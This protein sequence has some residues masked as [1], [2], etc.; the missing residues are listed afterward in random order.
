MYTAVLN[1]EIAPNWTKLV[2]VWWTRL[3]LVGQVGS[4]NI[5]R[6]QLWQINQTKNKVNKG[7][8]T[9]KRYR[10]YRESYGKVGRS[11][12]GVWIQVE[13]NTTNLIRICFILMEFEISYLDQRLINL[14][15]SLIDRTENVPD[16]INMGRLYEG[17]CLLG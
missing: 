10:F 12:F 14:A 17:Q 15:I 6:C 5:K 4:P 8:W 16:L 3:H 11:V 13:G 1:I 2:I 7:F 9:A